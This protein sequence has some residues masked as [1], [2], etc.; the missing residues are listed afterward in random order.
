MKKSTRNLACLPCG[1]GDR[2]KVVVVF[3]MKI[4]CCLISPIE[5]ECPH[6]LLLMIG[7][8]NETGLN[9]VINSPDSQEKH[10][11]NKNPLE[12]DCKEPIWKLN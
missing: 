12:L 2:R 6:A 3:S 8:N 10:D 7:N 4:C 1:D 11:E 9:I 5:A